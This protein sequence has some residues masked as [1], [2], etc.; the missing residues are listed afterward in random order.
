MDIYQHYYALAIE[1]S[2]KTNWLP[3]VILSQWIVDSP[4]YQP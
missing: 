2:K 4:L 1:A 3:E